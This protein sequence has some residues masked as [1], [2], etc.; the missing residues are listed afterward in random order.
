MTLTKSQGDDGDEKKHV[1]VHRVGFDAEIDGEQWDHKS[2]TPPPAGS[3]GARK[4]RAPAPE[5]H[6][7]QG[8]IHVAAQ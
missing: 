7:P 2:L 6:Y 5:H 8:A 3:A 1:F 4:R